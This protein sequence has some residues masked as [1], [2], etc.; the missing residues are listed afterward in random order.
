MSA[1][2]CL[3]LRPCCH[4]GCFQ[5]RSTFFQHGV[6]STFLLQNPVSPEIAE[7]NSLHIIH[8]N[9]FLVQSANHAIKAYLQPRQTI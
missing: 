3:P 2:R 9:T 1:K 4:P 5:L 8:Y 6:R 7:D